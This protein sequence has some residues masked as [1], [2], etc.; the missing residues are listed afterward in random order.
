[1]GVPFGEHGAGGR[2]GGSIPRSFERMV[3]RFHQEKLYDEVNR[4]VK[5]SGNEQMS[6]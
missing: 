1:M 2:G 3:K 4:H 5:S 6:P